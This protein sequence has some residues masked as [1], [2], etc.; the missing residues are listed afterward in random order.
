MVR[1]RVPV[2]ALYQHENGYE[3]SEER[4]YTIIWLSVPS[5]VVLE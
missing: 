1:V 2:P 3:L 5:V 4:A